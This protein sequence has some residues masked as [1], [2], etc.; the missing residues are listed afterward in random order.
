MLNVNLNKPPLYIPTKSASIQTNLSICQCH[1]KLDIRQTNGR[2]SLPS[3]GVRVRL[4][5][6]TFVGS[7]K[8]IFIVFG[9]SNSVKSN[10]QL[11]RSK[12][13]NERASH[14]SQD[15]AVRSSILID[16]QIDQ[17]ESEKEG[18]VDRRNDKKRGTYPFV[19]SIEQPTF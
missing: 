10:H 14:L 2:Y 18:E 12:K 15:S 3:S 11:T 6:R 7:G 9:S 13:A 8:S 1:S 17:S 16:T 19:P 5:D 4:N